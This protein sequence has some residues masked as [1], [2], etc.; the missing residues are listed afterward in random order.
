MPEPQMPFGL[1]SPITWHWIFPVFYFYRI[2]SA[3]CSSHAGFDHAAL[4][5]RTGSACAA[6][7]KFPVS[8]DKLA[9]RSDIKKDADR[10]FL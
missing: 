3:F 1:P 4:E 7:Q 5:C 2:N 6:E 9:V 10:F 8:D